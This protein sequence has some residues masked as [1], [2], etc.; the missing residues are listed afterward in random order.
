M[1][2][3]DV[4]TRHRGGHGAGDELDGRGLQPR[5]RPLDQRLMCYDVA[6]TGVR[7]ASGGPAE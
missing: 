6:E 7:D 3:M 4:A 1:L 2:S 5:R